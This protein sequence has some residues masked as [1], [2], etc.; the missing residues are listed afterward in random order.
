M[1]KYKEKPT[2]LA[3]ERAAAKAEEKRPSKPISHAGLKNVQHVHE[4]KA[5]IKKLEAENEIV[6]IKIFKEMD[7]Q[8]VDVL[9]RQGVEIVS[10]DDVDK[11]ATVFDED[12]FKADY[13]NLHKQYLKKKT[14]Y[15][16]INWKKLFLGK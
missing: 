12:R 2:S 15:K 5:Q 1:V 9:T 16:R 14:P 4:N 8:G 7:K 10:R 11:D 13:P 6:K 3:E